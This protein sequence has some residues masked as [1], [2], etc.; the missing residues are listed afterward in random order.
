MTTSKSRVAAKSHLSNSC[1]PT[2]IY[3]RQRK[4]G[5]LDVYIHLIAFAADVPPAS[6]L[7][8]L[9]H[10]H[11]CNYICIIAITITPPTF[12][13]TLQLQLLCAKNRK[14]QLFLRLVINYKS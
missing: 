4:A 7:D 10:L 13:V 3:A 8:Q 2:A 9:H 1:R 6:E 11:N 12:S 5:C 14:L